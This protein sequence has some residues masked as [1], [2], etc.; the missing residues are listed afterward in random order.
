M[1]CARPSC[2]VMSVDLGTVSGVMSG[3]CRAHHVFILRL[4]GF[5]WHSEIRDK[6]LVSLIRLPQ[7]S[8]L[9][10]IVDDVIYPPIELIK[11]PNNPGCPRQGRILDP[12]MIDPSLF[13]SWMDRCSNLHGTKCH[14]ELSR[15]AA[16][17]GG[18]V[19]LIDVR[20]NCLVPAHSGLRYFAL[21][22]V[23]GKTNG[24]ITKKSNLQRLSSFASLVSEHH[25]ISNT[26]LDAM[27]VVRLLGER[28][29]WVDCLCIVQDDLET[30]AA[31]INRMW[32]VYAGAFATIVAA[33]GSDAN[34]GL[35][36]VPGTTWQGELEQQFF[37][38][39]G[40]VTIA[41]RIF[42]QEPD[43]SSQGP[44]YERAWTFQELMCSTRLLVFERNSVRWECRCSCWFEDVECQEDAKGA[45]AIHREWRRLVG[46][47]FPDLSAYGA[48]VRCYNQRKLTFP[49]DA[50]FAIAG[51]TSLLSN[52]FQ[53]GFICGLPEL[54]FDIALLWAPWSHVHRRLP[55]ERSKSS[56]GMTHLPSWSWV[57]WEGDLDPW[58]W[59]SGC[60]YD[61]AHGKCNTS[62]ETISILQW[63]ANTEPRR[64]GS[65]AI[66]AEFGSYKEQHCTAQELPPGW[67]RHVYHGLEGSSPYMGPLRRR[68]YFYTHE[69]NPSFELWYPI[70]LG[71]VRPMDVL[72]KA[73]EPYLLTTTNGT[74][75]F[76]K[77]LQIIQGQTR[78][79]LYDDEDTWVGVLRLHHVDDGELLER[80]NEC[81]LV[82]VSRGRAD[83]SRENEPGLDEW[84]FEERPR[85]GALYEFYNVLW[86]SWDG[87]IAYRRGAGRVMRESW[88]AMSLKEV[89]L[90]LA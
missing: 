43:I 52:T 51:M 57:G 19:L 49:E 58:I 65:R 66:R 81:E 56:G 2:E 86:I 71:D 18:P 33:Q 20:Q 84:E 63:F 23:W 16:E 72:N 10:V 90:I 79:S 21:S 26:V 27:R 14:G 29:L 9:Q 85:C 7:H 54:F 42:D 34:H 70:P 53:G 80:D 38:V 12:S 48:M 61:K 69:S 8:A 5:N 73:P 28:Y 31:Q 15:Y 41:E 64:D 87:N 46:T 45:I 47:S 30:K 6:R 68:R 88:E 36:R 75:L 24:L 62:R 44:W 82:A 13:K 59:N 35:R 78:A 40:D 74:T 39:A 22:Y 76:A 83:N 50:I 55:S 60:D 4:V 25:N 3:T 32:E 11:D 1:L 67:T 89:F 77:S 17:S 37:N